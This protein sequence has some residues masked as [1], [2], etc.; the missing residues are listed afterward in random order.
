MFPIEVIDGA[1][2]YQFASEENIPKNIIK[3]DLIGSID[4]S[5]V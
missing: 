1:A 2:H 3:S 4:T 5:V